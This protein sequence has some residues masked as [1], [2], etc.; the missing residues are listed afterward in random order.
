MKSAEGTE[1]ITGYTTEIITDIALDWLKEGRD[2]DKPF[3]L[4]CQHKAPHRNWQPGPD[5]LTM[6]DDVE[7]PESRLVLPLGAAKH[8]SPLLNF[9]LGSRLSYNKIGVAWGM[10]RAAIDA[11]DAALPTP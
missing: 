5:Y 11:F 3:M 2:K 10:T 7:I 9:P 4:M 8:D 6:Y 1:K